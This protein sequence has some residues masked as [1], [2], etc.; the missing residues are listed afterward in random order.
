MSAISTYLQ[1][2]INAIWARDVR[3]AIHDAISQCYDDVNAPALQTEAMQAAVQA[4]IDAGEMA[5]LTIADGSLTGA[6][7]A[8]GTIPTAK[9]ADGAITAGKLASGAVATDA[10]LTQ[11]G[12]PADAKAVGDA[13]ASIEPGLSADA[14]AALLNCFMHVAWTD[15]HGQDYYDDLFYAL[16]GSHPIAWDIEWG[17]GDGSP[18][19]NGFDKTSSGLY[20][21]MTSGG[22]RM[23]ATSDSTGCTLVHVPDVLYASGVYEFELVPY[24]S[25]LN[26]N[27][28]INTF[29]PGHRLY[30]H[31]GNLQ[32]V[33]TQN[34]LDGDRVNI[35]TIVNNRTYVIRC[36][37]D[38]TGYAKIYLN[39][40]LI[41]NYQNALNAT[42]SRFLI[43]VYGRETV[44]SLRAIRFKEVSA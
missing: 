12:I 13:I 9:I 18:I 4:K 6:K 21:E 25:S 10:T 14:K 42:T 23:T 34:N 32:F 24:L 35:A 29:M 41:Y 15:E 44:A 11:S 43:G 27:C 1:Q 33:A 20:G 7:L 31:G 36:E 39:G 5:A 37:Y 30:I 22:Y 19:D 8:D 26:P 40:E 38:K 28:T 16:Y 2:I 17:A 3:K